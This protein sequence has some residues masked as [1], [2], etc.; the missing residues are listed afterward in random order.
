MWRTS[1]HRKER[2]GESI[3][4]SLLGEGTVTEGRIYLLIGKGVFYVRGVLGRNLRWKKQ[5]KRAQVN[6]RPKKKG[7]FY[8]R[9]KPRILSLPLAKVGG[10]KHR[11]N[12]RLLCSCPGKSSPKINTRGGHFRI[13][14]IGIH[15]NTQR[16]W[17]EDLY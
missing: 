9:K 13:F 16:S 6:P 12:E 17:P 15:F 1:S 5:S 11:H 2:K 14:G 3:I 8:M 7:L 10:E 4:I